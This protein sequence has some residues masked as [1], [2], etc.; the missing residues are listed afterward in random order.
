MRLKAVV[1]YNLSELK[2]GIL[3][4]YCIIAVI[5]A[6]FGV[7]FISV[8][9]NN[10]HS[11]MGGVDVAT[12]IF[13][14]VVGLSSFKQNFLLLSAYGVTR[15]VQFYGFLIS[16]LI[17]SAFMSAV[18]TAYGNI[19]TGFINYNPVFHQIYQEWVSA[20]PKAMVILTGFMWSTV[21][22]FFELLLGYTITSLYYRMTRILKIVVSISVPVLLFTVFPGLDSILTNG[23]IYGWIGGLFLAMGGLKDGVNPF[24]AVLSLLVESIIL[25]VLAF[26]LM[27]KA[28]VKE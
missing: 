7:S 5:I 15:K 3:I 16:S 17:V 13:L 21:L 27:R 23:K 14:F 12:A 4:F 9:K 8:S 20:V 19:L 6:F 25:A 10:V 11:S 28:A 26:L 24:I 22:Y 18:D 2:N 1:K